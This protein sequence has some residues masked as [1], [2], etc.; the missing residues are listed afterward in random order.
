LIKFG[1]IL[2]IRK[3]IIARKHFRRNMMQSL[4]NMDLQSIKIKIKI[5]NKIFPPAKAGG[6]SKAWGRS[7]NWNVA[8]AHSCNYKPACRLLS[9]LCVQKKGAVGTAPFFIDG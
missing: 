8:L 7:M 9:S 3:N 4:T 2:K 6:N 5:K 1:N